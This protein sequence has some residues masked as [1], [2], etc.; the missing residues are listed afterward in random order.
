[1]SPGRTLA[2]VT[3]AQVLAIASATVVAVALPAIGD[4]LDAEGAELQWVIDA[5]VLVFAALVVAGGVWGDRHGRRLAFTVGLTVFAAGSLV[6]ALAQSVEVLLAGRVLMG[7]GPPLVLP[8]SLAIV[9]ATYEDPAA[10]ARAVGLWAMG[11]G[12][13]VAAGPMLGGLLVDGLGWRAVFAFNVPVAAALVLVAWR[14]VARDR[15][16]R[17]AHAFDAPGAALLTAGL[18]CLVFGTIEGRELGWSSPAAVGVFSAAA[19][20][21]AAFGAWERRHP[22]PL[23]DFALVRER[24]FVAANAGGLLIFFALFGSI[25]LFSLFLQ[26]V[27]GRSAV[28]TGLCL[29][30][31]GLG[32]V[33]VAPLAG[34]LTAAQGPRVPILVGL[35]LLLAGLG[36]LLG[37]EAGSSLGELWWC[38]ALLGVGAGLALPPMTV[39]A[40]AA[41]P[42]AR[43]GMASAV[44]NASRQLGQT[45]G[46]AVLGTIVLGRA[47]DGGTAGYV[48]GL[49]VATVVSMVLLVAALV[50]AAVLVPRGRLAER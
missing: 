45:F 22:A 47:A 14:V 20:L 24:T 46:V 30:P 6:C 16:A 38:F 15:P 11:S 2:T 44:H 29:L 31:Q 41:A 49:H 26:D 7:L 37:V 50:L 34:R 18:A 4:D 40:L 27:Q 42:A 3:A 39:T 17:P 10:R 43:T 12:T 32:I 9:T 13:G 23:V 19:V 28:E 21:L 48:D 33:L 8:A 25:V 36:G 5:F 35:V 1:V